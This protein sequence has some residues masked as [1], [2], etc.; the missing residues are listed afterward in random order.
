MVCREQLNEATGGQHK[1]VL[2]AQYS[3]AGVGVDVG[4]QDGV[5]IISQVM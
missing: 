4:I 2:E 3:H 1:L 5:Q